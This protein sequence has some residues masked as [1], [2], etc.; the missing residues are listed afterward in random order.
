M[1][2]K[3]IV[4]GKLKQ[5]EGKA[6]ANVGDATDS[7]KHE[8]QGRLKEAEGKV[9]EGFGKVKAAVKKAVDG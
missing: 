9:Q 4:A 2:N 5:V 1:T 3:D 8:V 7:P 6:E